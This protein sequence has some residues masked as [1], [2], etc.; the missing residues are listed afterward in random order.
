MQLSSTKL[1]EDCWRT[2]FEGQHQELGFGNQVCMPVIHHSGD[3]QWTTDYT[4]SLE[5]KGEVWT[6]YIFRSNQYLHNI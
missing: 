3:F 1:G 6:S 4:Y 5:F 2:R